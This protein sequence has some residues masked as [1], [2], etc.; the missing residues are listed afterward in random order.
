MRLLSLVA[1]LISTLLLI[2]PLAAQGL[3]STP[4]P[5]DDMSAFR[6][7]GANWQIAGT[8]YADRATEHALTSEPGT[9]VLVNHPS[10]SARDNL[11][12]AFEHGD[13]ELELDVMIPKGSNSGL[14]LQGRYELQL[15][16]SWGV[17][18]PRYS[19]MGGIYQRWDEARGAG[20]EGY[21]GH[22]PRQNAARAPGLWQHLHLLFQA[23]RFDAE[24][25]KTANARFVRVELNGVVLH[26]NVEVTGPT[27]GPAFAD[28]QPLGPLMIQGDHGPLAFRNIR[29]KHYRDQHIQLADLR[30]RTFEG[31]FEA[32]PD[33]SSLSPSHEGSLDGLHWDLDGVEDQFTR[34]IEGQIEL[35]ESG[36]YAFD[37][38]LDWFTGDPHFEGKKIGGG[39]LEIGGQAVL[40]H[41][42]TERTAHATATL[43]AGR[44]PFRFTYY[45]NRGWAAPRLALYAEGPGVPRQTLNAPGTLSA[46]GPSVPLP[47]EPEGEVR[48][49]RSFV[50]HGGTKHT[51]PLSVG[52][53]TG[54]HY[55]VDLDT[56]ALLYVWRGP[57]LDAAA[58]WRSRGESQLARPTGSVVTLP[59]TPVVFGA[60]PPF[61]L[62]GY[63]LDEAGRPTIE[64]EAEGVRVFDQVQPDPTGTYLTRT[65]RFEAADAPTGLNVHLAA[66]SAIEQLP[67]GSFAVDDHAYYIQAEDALPQIREASGG[68]ELVLPVRF[69]GGM[70]TVRYAIIW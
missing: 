4:V 2:E 19:D 15:L 48:L 62:Q 22:P 40:R 39:V 8:V 16:D 17:D 36:L 47:V 42:G 66:G 52:D 44:Q 53:P 9:G 46:G 69:E 64:Y 57:F 10:A 30:Y 29:Y 58:M 41:P 24:G 25:N 49:L 37:L 26:E 3:P 20:Q 55:T 34:V 7:T 54:V 5:L 70:A 27:R 6:T 33:V 1:F 38:S 65:L 35:P 43:A 67:D 21:E 56:G 12:T 63:V 68:Q 45:K 60:V 11:F 18:Q 14:Y 59:G 23:P 50:M 32:I 51:R 28:E 31:T 61:V 13:L